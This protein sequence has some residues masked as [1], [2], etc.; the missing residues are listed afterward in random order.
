MKEKNDSKNV[1]SVNE[2]KNLKIFEFSK[3][4]SDNDESKIDIDD[5]DNDD[6][7][8]NRNDREIIEILNNE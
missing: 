5:D 4:K 2:K 3:K 8:K 6:E 7:K 1:D